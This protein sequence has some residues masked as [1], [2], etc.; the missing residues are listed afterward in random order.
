MIVIINYELLGKEYRS[1][2]PLEVEKYC[3]VIFSITKFLKCNNV[4]NWEADIN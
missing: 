2:L 1:G 4:D 3:I